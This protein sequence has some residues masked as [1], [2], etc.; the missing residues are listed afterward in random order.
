MEMEGQRS[1][2]STPHCSQSRGSHRVLQATTT[3]KRTYP[4]H[5]IGDYSAPPD[6]DYCAADSLI[7]IAFPGTA[8]GANCPAH[9]PLGQRFRRRASPGALPGSAIEQPRRN[10]GPCKRHRCPPGE[11]TVGAVPPIE[12]A[13]PYD[14]RKGCPPG[15]G[16]SPLH[17]PRTVS[18]WFRVYRTDGSHESLRTPGGLP[19]CCLRVKVPS[20]CLRIEGPMTRFRAIVAWWTPAPSRL[21]AATYIQRDVRFWPSRAVK[22]VQV[23]DGRR[24]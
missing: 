15:S 12:N 21:T 23:T 24:L 2:P 17:S 8:T 10:G 13:P 18:S 7:P 6:P 22:G 16:T 4:A 9:G 5:A 19:R 14:T 3:K 1:C 20:C 11:P